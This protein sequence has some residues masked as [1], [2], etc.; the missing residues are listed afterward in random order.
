MRILIAAPSHQTVTS[1]EIIA[2]SIWPGATFVLLARSPRSS[3]PPQSV[4]AM[5]C[6]LCVLD[7]L[8]LG[9][10]RWCAEH[11]ARLK[12]LLAGRGAI[13]LVP[14]GN[15]GE[16]LDTSGSANQHGRIVLQR[17]V[18]AGAL[19]EALRAAGNASEQLRESNFHHRHGANPWLRK[20]HADAPSGWGSTLSGSTRRSIPPQESASRMG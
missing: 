8:G 19:I 17:P 13:L 11:E 10:S 1:V 4:A 3:I 16:W 14:P 12:I 2:R 18:T 15:G 7:L 20:P 6:D 9:W 5:Q